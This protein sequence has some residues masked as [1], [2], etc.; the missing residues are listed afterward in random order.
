MNMPQIRLNDAS[1]E[2]DAANPYLEHDV[3]HLLTALNSSPAENYPFRHWLI[4]D[5]FDQEIVDQILEL[6]FTCHKLDYERGSREEHNPTRQYFNPEAIEKYPASRRIAEAFRDMRVIAKFEEMGQISLKETLLRMEYCLDTEGF[7]LEPHTDIGVKK[8]TMLIYMSKEPDALG[9]GTDI[10]ES[11]DKHACTVPFKTNSA[12]MF[13][14]SSDTWHGFERRIINGIRKTL[15]V[16][17][18]TQEW[19]N[20]HEL[21]DPVKPVY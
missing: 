3:A 2:T 19:R 9:W 12:L 17:Y 15:I 16:N 14:P 5:L 6:P 18:V 21:T 11:K 10:Y 8:F 1:F 7:W 4:N 20:R 13:I